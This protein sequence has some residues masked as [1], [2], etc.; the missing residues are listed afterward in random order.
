MA[1]TGAAT[2]VGILLYRNCQSAMVHGLTD[3][4]MTASDF[5]VARGGRTLRLSHWAPD[6]TGLFGRIF[7]SHPG[8]DSAADIL[9]APGVC[10][11]R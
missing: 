3:M 8:A 7:D 10:P 4:L 2:E 5:S 11:V 9:V 6:E 1:G